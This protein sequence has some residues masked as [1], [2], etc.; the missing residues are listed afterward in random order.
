MHTE[1]VL[2][3]K[4]YLEKVDEAGAELLEGGDR[5]RNSLPQ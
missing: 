3:G 5:W 4:L 2:V 1:R